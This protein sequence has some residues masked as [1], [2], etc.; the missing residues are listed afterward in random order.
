M[1]RFYRIK[2]VVAEY[3]VKNVFVLN[4]VQALSPSAKMSAALMGVALVSDDDPSIPAICAI[5]E[6]RYKIADNYKIGFKALQILTND[7][8][9]EIPH[10]EYTLPRD[11]YQ[12]DF[13]SIAS[14]QDR[15]ERP[16]RVFVL[17]GDDQYTEVFIVDWTES[18]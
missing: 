1:K 18:L 7:G 5:D 13:N 4:Y 10:M 6:S 9:I 3:G 17:D 8:W 16:L 15:Y 12:S 2:D 11:M 14:E